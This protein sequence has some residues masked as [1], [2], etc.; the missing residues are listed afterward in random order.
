MA[1]MRGTDEVEEMSRWNKRRK[2]LT[3]SP[4]EGRL[5]SGEGAIPPSS[6]P[7]RKRTS[8][9]MNIHKYKNVIFVLAVFFLGVW[10]G[11][12][13]NR[14]NI[15]KKKQEETPLLK[16]LP[17]AAGSL[18]K[19]LL[20][21][22]IPRGEDANLQAAKHSLEKYINECI[23]K[24]YALRISVYLMDLNTRNWIGIGEDETYS[25]ASL[26]KTPIMMAYFKKDEEDP[27]FLQKTIK[28]TA[29]SNTLPQNISPERAVQIGNVH[30]LDD[31]IRYMIIYSDNVAMEL[32]IENMDEKFMEKVRM[33]LQLPPIIAKETERFISP[34]QFATPLQALYN[35]SYLNTSSSEKALVLLTQTGFVDG[36]VAGVPPGTV[37]A[38][39]FAE[40]AYV[41]DNAKRL[42]DCGI[43]YAKK[44]PYL[45]CVM[46]KG[47]DF[48]ELKTIIRNISRIAYEY[49][50]NRH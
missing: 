15:F 32:L 29:H 26:L 31:L 6:P 35:A 5:M 8:M 17:T 20:E 22:D 45:I 44:G 34:K 14:L 9:K 36:L 30:T 24:R 2:N 33:D 21:V 43:V 28:Y 48:N 16:Y 27:A 50:E 38:H 1:P 11:L 12:F 18:V 40:R 39:K 49:M 7:V 23:K 41:P 10:V 3:K 4:S 42:H 13:F 25:I 37:V 19:P 47:W 46:T